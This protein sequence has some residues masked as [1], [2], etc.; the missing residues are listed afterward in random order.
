MDNY[1]IKLNL[2]RLSGAFVSTLK[3]KQASKRCLCIPIDDAHLFLGEK[4][5]YLD[6]NAWAMR[7]GSPYGHTHYLKQRLT[8]QTLDAMAD[9]ARRAM[10][11]VGDMAPRPEYGP[12]GQP[13]ASAQPA[14]Q[15][16]AQEQ[17]LPQR[18]EDL[19]F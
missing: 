6:L 19:P 7:E 15:P 14:P 12:D 16:A 8:K 9:E 4:G 3:G 11:I 13:A 2:L 5:C 10:P 17:T 18:D 1:R